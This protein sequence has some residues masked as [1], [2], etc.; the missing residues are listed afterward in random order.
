MISRVTMRK[1]GLSEY[2][3]D[4]KRADSNLLRDDKDKVMPLYGSLT[5]F[6]KVEL[7]CNQYKTWQS[8]YEHITISFS[9]EDANVLNSL[10]DEAYSNTLKDIVLKT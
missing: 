10:S 8:N 6:K 9:D 2:L 4:G 7:Y 1:V 3:E 5:T